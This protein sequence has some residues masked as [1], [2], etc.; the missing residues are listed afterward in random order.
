MTFR[1]KNNN[2]NNKNKNK[3]FR[4]SN[5]VNSLQIGGGNKLDDKIKEEIYENITDRVKKE[6]NKMTYY[7]KNIEESIII[8]MKDCFNIKEYQIML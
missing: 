3:T 6:H 1:N 4:N 8:D 5:H 2:N 7:N